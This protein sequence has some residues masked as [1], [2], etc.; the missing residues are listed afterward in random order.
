MPIEAILSK[1][2]ALKDV[3]NIYK[4]EINIWNITIQYCIMYIE[5]FSFF[6]FV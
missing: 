1:N 2:V 6:D 3:K 4:I 5:K